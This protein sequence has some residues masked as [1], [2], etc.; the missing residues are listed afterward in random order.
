MGRRYSYDPSKGSFPDRYAMQHVSN[1]QKG[2]GDSSWHNVSIS[3]PEIFR[4]AQRKSDELGIISDTVETGDMD[5]GSSRSHT[6]NGIRKDF[7][8]SVDRR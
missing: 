1:K 7:I 5:S 2:S 8:V 4:S 6:G 3:R